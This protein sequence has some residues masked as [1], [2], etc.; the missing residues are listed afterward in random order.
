MPSYLHEDEP[1]PER[2]TP[3]GTQANGVEH[4]HEERDIDFRA[5]TKWFIG[6]AVGLA[7]S[8]AF[9]WF[10]LQVTLPMI[11]GRDRPPSPVFEARWNLPT[12]RVLPNPYDAPPD[13]VT[14]LPQPLLGPAGYLQE[15]LRAESAELDR[16]E[17]QYPGTY[18]D[19]NLAGL[20]RLPESAV[21]AVIAKSAGSAAAGGTIDG[22]R[23]MGP[24]GYSG[25]TRME[26]VL[27]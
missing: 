5:T 17:L 4:G 18:E 20:A 16:L 23:E 6:L 12:P 2:T 22:A 9:V 11:E 1:L 19:P 3:Q 8:L 25:G 14:S 21:N 27:R 26:N 13:R 10:G 7:L 15:Q 24:A